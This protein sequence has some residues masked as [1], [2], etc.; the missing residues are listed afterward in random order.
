MARSRNTRVSNM[1]PRNAVPPIKKLI[2]LTL[3]PGEDD[4]LIAWFDGLP[5]NLRAAAVKARLRGGTA[6]SAASTDDDNS[7]SALDNLLA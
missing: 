6:L 3:H 5:D 7:T 2:K 4:D 1:R